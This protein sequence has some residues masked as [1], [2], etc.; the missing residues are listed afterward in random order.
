MAT[1]Y[2]N[3]VL[4]EAAS[5]HYNLVFVHREHCGWP[6]NNHFMTQK[7]QSC[8]RQLKSAL[9]IKNHIAFV[10]KSSQLFNVYA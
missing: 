3:M 6:P 1:K 2:Q 5:K 4:K 7:G 8:A 9:A 10:A